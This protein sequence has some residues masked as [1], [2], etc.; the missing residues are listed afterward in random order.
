ML[1]SRRQLVEKMTF[2]WHD[3][4]ATSAL[5]VNQV[6]GNG[7]ALMILQNQILRSHA[8]GNFKEMVRAISSDPAMIIWLDNFSNVVGNPNENWARELL[9]LFTMGEG[10]GYT[11]LDIQEAA[12]AFTGWTLIPPRRRDF[13]MPLTF[14]FVPALHDAGPKM[15]LGTPIAG[16][17]GEAGISDAEQVLD[18]VFQQPV[19]A[20]FIVGKLW[21]A[22]VYPDPPAGLIAPLAALFRDSGYELKPL[23]EALF[24]HPHFMSKKALRAKIKS[25]IE[26]SIGAFRELQVSAPDNLPRVTA[27]FALGQNLFQPPDVG[28]WTENQGW[29]N[30]GTALARANFMV[31][32]TS[33]RKGESV[34]GL[35]GSDRVVSRFNDQIPVE[36]ILADNNLQTAEQVVDFFLRAMVPG[37]ASLDTRYSL[38]EYLRT[39]AE[40][41]PRVFD[42]NDPGQVDEKVRGLIFLISLL[43]AY[44]LN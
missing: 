38:E 18:I 15:F 33:N 28:G 12:R 25:P 17:A 9:E 16:A 40:G 21:S 2:L 43:P 41:E 37:A 36:E 20:E 5:T 13:G 11:E 42:V 1:H 19:V 30:T 6:D 32:T 4:F 27:Y 24:T 29:I 34:G 26:F 14:L 22:F 10:N 3:H 35:G 8:L 23:M 44:Q 31:F 7:E 39:G